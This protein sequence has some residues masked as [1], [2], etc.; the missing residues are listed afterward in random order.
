MNDQLGIA[1]IWDNCGQIT[2][3]SSAFRDLSKEK[4]SPIRS[5]SFFLKVNDDENGIQ[6]AKMERD[7]VT[8]C[9]GYGLACLG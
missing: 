9:H 4:S 6:A 8:F 1:R 2:R 5:Q 3:A 7:A